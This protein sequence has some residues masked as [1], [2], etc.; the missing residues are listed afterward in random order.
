MQR[1]NIPF[2][3]SDTKAQPKPSDIMRPLRGTTEWDA[4][5]AISALGPTGTICS[6]PHGLY[7]QAPPDTRPGFSTHH[8]QN[9]TRV[10]SQSL[11]PYLPR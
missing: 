6:G 9:L 5:C 10:L 11:N 8:L 4:G 2:Q 3:L 7:G 1:V